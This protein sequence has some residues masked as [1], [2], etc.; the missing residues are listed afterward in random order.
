MLN[1]CMDDHNLFVAKWN[2]AKLEVVGGWPRTHLLHDKSLGLCILA[3]KL[4]S[5]CVWT[6]ICSCLITATCRILPCNGLDWIAIGDFWSHPRGA[7]PPS[8]YHLSG[9]CKL[10]DQ[11]VGSSVV[12]LFRGGPTYQ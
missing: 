7:T 5:Q 4:R 10:N 12:D 6:L 2:A 3:G 11:F 8:L 9:L 1:A